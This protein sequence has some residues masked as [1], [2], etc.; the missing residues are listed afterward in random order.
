M[1]LF[2]MAIATFLASILISLPIAR[3]QT[4]PASAPGRTCPPEAVRATTTPTPHPDVQ[5]GLQNYV[6]EQLGNGPHRV[7][8]MGDSIMQGW[9]RPKLEAILGAKVL[10]IGF[11]G[12]GTEQVL[13]RLNNLDWSHQKP[14]YVLLLVGTND[15]RFPACAIVQGIL[16]TVLQLHATFPNASLIV[17]GILP[18]GE[19]LQQASET[20]AMVNR[21]IKAAAPAH[22]YLF[23]DAHDTFMNG[24]RYGLYAPGNLHLSADGYDVLGDQLRRLLQR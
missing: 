16:S 19:R 17:V 13:W 1:W 15:I 22:Q 6:S 21:E 14:E 5:V 20:I 23:L 12:D 11:G 18:R 4:A 10:N 24:D 9:P 7:I 2:P 3:A 8:A